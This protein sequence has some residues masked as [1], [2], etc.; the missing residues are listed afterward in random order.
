VD[1][2]RFLTYSLQDQRLTRILAASIEAVEP[3]K[4]VRQ[5]LEN[6][7]PPPYRRLF[8][9]GIGKA[10]EPMTMSAAGF[11]KDFTDA[12]I[13]TKQ[14]TRN[15]KRNRLSRVP[16]NI[17]IIESGHPV[18][19]E[20]SLAAGHAVLDFISNLKKDDLLICLISG[21]GSSLVTAPRAGVSLGDIQLLTSSMLANGADIEELNIIRCLCDRLKGGGL[22]RATE[23]KIISLIL[24]DVIGDN[25]EVIASGPTVPGSNTVKEVSVILE[26]YRISYLISGSKL[27]I[28]TGG[29]IFDYSFMNRVRNVLVANNGYALQAAKKQATTEGFLTQII[30]TQLQGEASA[31]GKKLA[32]SLKQKMRHK[33]KPICLISGGE[34]TVTIQGN[35][36][37]GRNQELALG[38]VETLDN[39]KKAMLISLATDGNDGPT[40]AAGAVVNGE[41]NR[42]AKQDNMSASEYL[43]RNDSFSFFE[44]LGDLLKPGYTGTNVNDIIFLFGL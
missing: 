26:K 38:A 7:T 19:D 36:K 3:G 11:F 14:S 37:G 15:T 23:G 25:L 17:T 28:L 16:R 43:S 20:R 21:G 22:A 10:A 29:M 4:I 9:L 40:E 5:K 24:S 2:D 33:T 1:A 27:N 35:G 30:N 13:I 8:L 34:T 44:S 6:I 31:A 12:L 32:T 41:T 42:R 18:P 39:V